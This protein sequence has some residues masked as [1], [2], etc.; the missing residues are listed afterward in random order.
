MPDRPSRLKV[1]AT[2][3]KNERRRRSA[4]H[5]LEDAREELADLL[6]EGQAAGLTV[7]AMSQIAKV[8][9]ET[10]HKLLRES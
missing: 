10:A 1:L 9:R 8:S 2:L 3:E 4:L 5:Q 6:H 7:S